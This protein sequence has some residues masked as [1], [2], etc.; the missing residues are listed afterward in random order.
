MF[1]DGFASLFRRTQS[2]YYPYAAELLEL[3]ATANPRET[4]LV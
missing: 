1:S 3:F 2:R 4:E